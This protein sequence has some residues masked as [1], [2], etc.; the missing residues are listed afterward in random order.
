MRRVHAAGDALSE[1]SFSVINCQLLATA[2]ALENMEEEDNTGQ[3]H[4]INEKLLLDLA[5]ERQ[6]K[7]VRHDAEHALHVFH[8]HSPCTLIKSA[9]VLS[10]NISIVFRA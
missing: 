2:L 3:Q 5:W 6:Q 7:K 1:G 8:L 4:D 10:S 9:S